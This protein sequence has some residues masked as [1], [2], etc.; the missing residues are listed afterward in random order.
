MWGLLPIIALWA[1]W[2]YVGLGAQVAAAAPCPSAG[3][4]PRAAPGTPN[5]ILILLDDLDLTLGG[6]NP[7]TKTRH[8]LADKGANASNWFMLA[9]LVAVAVFSFGSSVM[10]L[11]SWVRHFCDS[12]F[13]MPE[14]TRALLATRRSGGFLSFDSSWPS[15]PLYLSFALSYCLQLPLP[16][17]AAD[18]PL[19]S[20]RQSTSAVGPV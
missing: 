3:P 2:F 20:Q 1:S 13:L 5:V 6:L 11:S 8:L 18:W 9:S 4:L 14:R 19:F 17:R 7:L 16:R 12:S 10:H 15:V